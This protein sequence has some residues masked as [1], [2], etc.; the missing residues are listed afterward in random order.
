[1]VLNQCDNEI[2]RHH[3]N[4]L[5]GHIH[6][7]NCVVILPANLREAFNRANT[8][9]DVEIVATESISDSDHF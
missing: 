9:D 3:S 6:N 8:L 7:R 1:M 4:Q 5:A 2:L